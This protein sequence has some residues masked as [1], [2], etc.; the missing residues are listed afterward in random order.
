MLY[1]M[2]VKW[3]GFAFLV[4]SLLSAASLVS[5]VISNG[6]SSEEEVNTLDQTTI[7]NQETGDSQASY[8]P[9]TFNRL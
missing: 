2:F 6:I 4:M 3:M 9:E 5:N 7:A 1:F 8:E